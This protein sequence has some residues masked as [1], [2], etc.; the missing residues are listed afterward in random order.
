MADGG[1]ACLF[2]LPDVERIEDLLGETAS[3]R[4][5]DGTGRFVVSLGAGPDATATFFNGDVGRSFSATIGGTPLDASSARD[6]DER[7]VK[8]RDARGVEMPVADDADPPKVLYGP[9]LAFARE[10]RQITPPSLTLVSLSGMCVY[11]L[12]TYTCTYFAFR[13]ARC[14]AE[15]ACVVC[16]V[17]T[18]VYV[19]CRI[20]MC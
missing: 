12:S 1:G 5:T 10:S 3:V 19:I 9:H 20:P 14:S 7:G 15:S 2:I 17:C 4:G 16:D 11:L 8:R 18:C 13:P 6:M